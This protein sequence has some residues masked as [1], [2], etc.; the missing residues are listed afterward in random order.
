MAARRGRTSSRK[1]SR[2]NQAE[3]DFVRLTGLWKPEDKRKK[4]LGRGIIK[5]EDLQDLV[6][7]IVEKGGDGAFVFL[8]KNEYAE[9]ANDPRYV[10]QGLALS[11]RDEDDD[12]EEERP[13]RSKK[14]KP[15]PKKRRRVVEEEDDED[16]EDD[17]DEEVPF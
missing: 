6:D 15:E 17:D 13:R 14:R 9:D 5:L 10:L 8:F 4:H 2:G 1:R 12:E 7:S 11:E 16:D 3:S